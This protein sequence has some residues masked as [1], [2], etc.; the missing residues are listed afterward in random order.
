MAPA[1]ITR[2]PTGCMHR[3]SIINEPVGGSI[4]NLWLA[5]RTSAA[6]PDGLPISARGARQAIAVVIW[7]LRIN[8]K[9][10]GTNWMDQDASDESNPTAAMTTTSIVTK[11]TAGCNEKAS[12]VGRSDQTSSE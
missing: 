2:L 9:G 12:F 4:R 6:A 7:A 8:S 10:Q 3:R 1:P 11:E 5:W